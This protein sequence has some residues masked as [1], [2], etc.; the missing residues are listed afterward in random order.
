LHQLLTDVQRTRYEEFTQFVA[1]NVE[2]HAALWE[3]QQQLPLDV[4]ARMASAG[5]LGAS[6]PV[7]FGGQG[8]DFVTFGLLNEAF[9]K[10]SSSLTGVLTVQAM[11]AMALVKWGTKSQKAEWLPRLASGDLIA[12]I[13]LTEPT[14]GSALRA[15]QTRYSWSPA[16]DSLRLNGTKR[17]ISCAQQAG[18]Y[19][20]YGQLDGQPVACL[21]P[22][23]SVGLSVKP[24]TDLMG[25]R[26]AGLA[27]LDFDN[28]E[29]P[30]AN[31][32]GKPGFGLSH[33]AQV[34]LH[35]G[36][37]STAC[38]ALGLLR[39]CFEESIAHASQRR[40]ESQ[41]VGE[42]G[43]IRTLIARMGTDLAAASGVC[44]LACRAEDD[45]DPQSFTNAL[46][47]KYFTSQAAVRAASDAVQIRG[48]SGC[49][50]SSPTAR[51]YQNAKIM[52]I[53]EGTTQIHEE[54]LGSI[55]VHQAGLLARSSGTV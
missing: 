10:A 26:A 16:R 18:V 19:L 50:E 46:I 20:V 12:S 38:S 49:H 43:M 8:W 15:M 7:E 23:E 55:F 35:H 45:R 40:I 3:Q 39:G 48:A 30:A 27:Q 51:Y 29:L 28:V 36:R 17:W 52:E 24:I 54:L 41:S 14:G 13:A 11:V 4:V 5:F 53:I 2:P 31:I 21:V 25:F 1:S 33:V 37:I 42:F 32:V 6:L 22:R 9:G 34:S 44:Y 47:A